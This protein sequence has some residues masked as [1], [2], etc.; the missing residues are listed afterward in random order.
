M[1]Y[2]RGLLEN[3]ANMEY[4]TDYMSR[5]NALNGHT[6]QA[7][8][9][10]IQKEY[11]DEVKRRIDCCRIILDE[12]KDAFVFYII[13]EL[14]DRCN[15]DESKDYLF[16]RPVRFH[17]I[18]SIR[19]NRK[20]AAPWALLARTYSWLVYLGGDR[21]IPKI[22]ISA[23]DEVIISIMRGDDLINTGSQK[24]SIEFSE[25]SIF[26]AKQATRLAPDNSEYEKLLR[27]CYITRTQEYQFKE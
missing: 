5:K 3:W 2:D 15:E 20:F 17:A 14:F 4:C 1:G 6:S 22:D 26:C 8:F 27:G 19:E 16:K 10:K 24:L 7:R 13:A 21:D 9:L 12:Q 23:K 25:R 18:K 11:F